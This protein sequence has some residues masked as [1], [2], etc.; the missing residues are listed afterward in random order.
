M[1]MLFTVFT[2]VY[3]KKQEDE[4]T[5]KGYRYTLVQMQEIAGP[6]RLKHRIFYNPSTGK[7]ALWF[8]AVKKGD[9]KTIKKMVASGQDIEAI[10][11]A[12]LNQTALGW[13][14]FIG[15]L[16]IVEYLVSKGANLNATD[17]ADVWNV[18]KSA[19]LGH[20]GDVFR[21]LLPLFKGYDLNDQKNDT[22]GE[23]LMIIATSNN[24]VEIVKE[25]IKQ[26]ADI[27]L[28]TPYWKHNPLSLACER[29]FVEIQ[30]ALI[31]AGAINYKTGKN[32]C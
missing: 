5:K 2:C 29:N 18:L 13:A 30:E 11:T 27:N 4:Y 22:Q 3:A 23:N 7:D 16:D 20:N 14:A 9:L 25:L 32:G 1:I 26:G 10:D 31:K 17:K 21:F 6:N 8:D 24:R 15:Y 19:T 12:S 28:H